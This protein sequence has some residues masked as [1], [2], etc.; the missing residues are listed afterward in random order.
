MFSKGFAKAKFLLLLLLWYL[1]QHG[2]R[3]VKYLQH[4]HRKCLNI[5]SVHTGISI[6]LKLE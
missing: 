2:N 6:I 5:D 1:K 3:C 4:T